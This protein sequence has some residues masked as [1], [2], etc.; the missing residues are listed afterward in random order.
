MLPWIPETR[1]HDRFRAVKVHL[2]D[3]DDDDRTRLLAANFEAGEQL[4]IDR[5]PRAPIDA[6]RFADA[7][8]QEEQRDARI[9]DDVLEIINSIVAGPI[10]DS[11][12]SLVEDRHESSRIALRRT[13]RSA[14]AH[15]SQHDER[16][17]S[18]ECLVVLVQMVDFFPQRAL[19]R[20]AVD[21]FELLER[22]DGMGH[23]DALGD[24]EEWR[25]RY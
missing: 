11:Q 4:R 21:R 20:L 6:Q 9:G 16:R 23:G 7:R 12:R 1:A 19:M 3:A 5:Y 17:R 10:G 25:Y 18:N 24:G 8:D 13:V 14:F 2:L 15:R 22:G